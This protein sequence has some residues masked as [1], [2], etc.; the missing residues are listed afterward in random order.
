MK[1]LVK[2]G[3]I[4][5]LLLVFI[6]CTQP[7]N[8]TL[9]VNPLINETGTNVLSRFNA[10][11][12]FERKPVKQASFAQYLQNLPLK[13]V[14][15]K[16]K[17]YNGSIKHKDVYEA[18]VNLDIDNKNLQQCADAI[19]RL[20]AEYFYAQKAYNNISFNLT[21][22]FRVDYIEWI[23]GN[24]IINKGNQAYWQKS[25]VP[26]NTYKDFRNY[27]NFVFAY[28]GTLSLDKSL[29]NKD[30]KNIAIGDVFIIGG[31]PGHAVIVVDVAENHKCEKIFL[32][33]QSYMPAQEIQILKNP[34]DKQLSPWYSANIIDELITPEWTFKA[35]HLKSWEKN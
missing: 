32:L 18:V 11:K 16:V 7:V 2:T 15:T 22:G 12:G 27:L 35:H 29:Y 3:C 33:V 13:A 24:R 23:K 28:A 25:A 26:S 14:G 31:S 34:N 5:L 20:R 4:A 30:L 6:C 9:T 1:T 19:M 10:P 8:Y 21:N 17:Y